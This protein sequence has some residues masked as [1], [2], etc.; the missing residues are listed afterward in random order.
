MFWNNLA[1]AADFFVKIALELVLL[2]IGVT[3]LVGLIQEYVPD[4]TVKKVLG[5]RN[6]ILGGVLGAGF[7]SLTPFCSCSTIPLLL[8][9]LNA[10]VPFLRH[11]LPPIVA[12][13][14]PGDNLAIHTAFGLEGDGPLLCCDLYGGGRH[15]PPS[16]PSR[17]CGPGETDGR[18]PKLP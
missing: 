5:G 18:D 12:A 13:A 11:G 1:V 17:L 8:G 4:E 15:R 9:M 7:G 3:F 10:G 2:F 14:E 16:G 6:R